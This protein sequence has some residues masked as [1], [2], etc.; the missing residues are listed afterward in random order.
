MRK[1][2]HAVIG[3]TRSSLARLIHSDSNESVN[4]IAFVHRL[5]PYHSFSR[6]LLDSKNK[7][8][9]NLRNTYPS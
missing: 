6:D 4:T 3:H 1:E 5:P 2:K 7:D 9:K 8:M